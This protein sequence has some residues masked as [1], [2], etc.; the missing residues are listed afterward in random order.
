MDGVGLGPPTTHVYRGFCGCCAPEPDG[1]ICPR[2]IPTDPPAGVGCGCGRSRVSGCEPGGSCWARWTSAD[3]WI[4]K[5][6]FLTPPLSPRKKGLRGRQDPSD[7]K[8][9]RLNSSHLG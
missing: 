6:H 9:T 3:C 7:R 2:S 4:G 8:S 1:A 5:K